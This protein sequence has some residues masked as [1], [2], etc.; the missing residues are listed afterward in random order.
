MTTS[1]NVSGSPGAVLVVG[2]ADTVDIRRQRADDTLTIVGNGGT[3][4]ASTAPAWT[5]DTIQLTVS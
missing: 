4:H 3:R 2:P 5:P 1:I